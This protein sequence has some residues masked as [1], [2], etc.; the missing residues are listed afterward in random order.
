MKTPVLEYLCYKETPTQV[1]FY[2][3]PPVAASAT[4]FSGNRPMATI[5]I[6]TILQSSVPLLF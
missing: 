3:T 2:K 5:S 6:K 1:F 4:I